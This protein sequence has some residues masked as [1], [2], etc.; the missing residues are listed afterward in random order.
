M[1]LS[2]LKKV[3]TFGKDKP[4]EGEPTATP[5]A[6]AV[7]DQAESTFSPEETQA[8]EAELEPHSRTEDL[9]V[10][11]ASV[12]PEEID[13]A[14]GPSADS[15]EAPEFAGETE[16]FAKEADETPAI[17]PAVEEI[18]D[19]GLAAGGGSRSVRD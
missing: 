17:L 8:I 19:I 14:G 1:A 16:T 11:E 2:F 12:L 5:A 13:T 7:M 3:F 4:A 18:G 9:P 6:D 15:A 10:A